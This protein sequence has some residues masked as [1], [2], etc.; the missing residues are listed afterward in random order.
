MK[1]IK[2]FY[3]TALSLFISVTANAAFP[4]TPLS[5]GGSGTEAD[6]YK[7]AT[8]DDLIEVRDAVNTATGAGVALSYYELA[9]NIDLSSIANWQWIGTYGGQFFK[10]NFDGKGYSITGVRLGSASERS[11][12]SA[13]GLFGY[14]EGATI[15]NLSV[16]VALYTNFTPNATNYG[17]MGGGLVCNTVGTG[18]NLI[19]NCKVTGIVDILANDASVSVAQSHVRV[20]GIVGLMNSTGTTTIINCAT[21][22]NL[23]AKN[24]G[25]TTNVTANAAAMCGGIVGDLTFG[26]VSTVEIVNCSAS[27]IVNATSTNFAA[28]AGGIL[29]SFSSASTIS[30]IINSVAKNSVISVGGASHVDA[31]AGGIITKQFN[32]SGITD[33][34]IALNTIISIEK[35]VSTGLF[36]Y[37][38]GYKHLGTFTNN[39]AQNGLLVQKTVTG[40]DPETVS[41]SSTY[42]TTNQG[43]DLGEDPINESITKLND[44]ITVN[45]TYSDIA[46]NSWT[47]GDFTTLAYNDVRSQQS[48]IPVVSQNTVSLNLDSESRSLQVYSLT[49]ERIKQQKVTG[50][51][52]FTLPKGIFILNVTG[53]KPCKI[54]IM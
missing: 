20:G 49:G 23:L 30:K 5:G 48:L 25:T 39:Y 4:T 27:G 31:Y 19:N 2:L 26:K 8:T 53:Y 24:A 12:S 47:N 1:K 7:I 54:I 33:H 46:L 29:S 13:A 34:C 45:P 6:P 44:Y 18:N 52:S 50:N 11:Y 22:V 10:G 36:L 3:L 41:I 17:T 15:S 38:I 43:A 40:G 21:N 28:Y 51:I 32:A 42:A 37:R 9:A 35:N 14:I 16:D